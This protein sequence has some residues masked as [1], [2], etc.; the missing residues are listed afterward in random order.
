K[1][2]NHVNIIDD[3]KIR[4]TINNDSELKEKLILGNNLIEYD[5][6]ND[7]KVHEVRCDSIN[8]YQACLKDIQFMIDFIE[9][10]VKEYE[11]EEQ[12]LNNDV[13]R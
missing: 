2:D 11:M 8:N 5:H 10:K 13:E 4:K 6:S 3:Y 7:F 12:N 1:N 9:D